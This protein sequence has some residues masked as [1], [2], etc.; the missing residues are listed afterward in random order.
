ENSKD[1]GG[2]EEQFID[3]PACLKYRAS[4]AKDAAQA[5][6]ARLQQDANHQRNRDDNLRHFYCAFIWFQKRQ[7]FILAS[8]MGL[9]AVSLRRPNATSARIIASEDAARKKSSQY[10]FS[11]SVVP[12]PFTAVPLIIGAVSGR[13][14]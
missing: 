1:N 10:Q 8:E 5:R 13:K 3:A 11:V 6:A 14:P 12:V 4:A 7:G 2:I 9:E